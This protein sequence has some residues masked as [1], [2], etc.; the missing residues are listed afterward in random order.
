VGDHPEVWLRFS[1]PRAAMDAFKDTLVGTLSVRDG[2]AVFISD[3]T[4]VTF[5]RVENVSFGRRG[6]DFMNKWIEVRG[7]FSGSPGT[8][9]LK[10]GGNRGWR[11]IL[12]GT[13]EPL[14][15]DIRALLES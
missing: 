15:S 6:S 9:F 2:G 10:D 7:V 8:A 11:P 12:H 14:F 13:N 4:T 1:R 5:D 3:S